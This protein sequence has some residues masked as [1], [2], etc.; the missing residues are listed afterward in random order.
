MRES[1]VRPRVILS[2][3]PHTRRTIR[4]IAGDA[5]RRLAAHRTEFISGLAEKK[6]AAEENDLLAADAMENLDLPRRLVGRGKTTHP[7]MWDSCRTMPLAGGFSRGSSV[8]PALSFRRCFIIISI[9]LIGSQALDVKSCPNLFTTRPVLYW[10]TSARCLVYIAVPD[11]WSVSME[12]PRNEVAGEIGYLGEKP[13][14]QR[15]VKKETYRSM[16]LQLARWRS[17][18]LWSTRIENVLYAFGRS[19]ATPPPPPLPQNMLELRA[20]I[21]TLQGMDYRR[22]PTIRDLYN[23]IPRHL[24]K[25]VGKHDGQASY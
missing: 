14:E 22:A 25:C 19:I 3:T 16:T 20:K 4:A 15:H 8:S 13:V 17:D 11:R 18:E 2:R 21:L 10:R 5:T 23:S 1:G 12:Q 9:T 6:L 7:R 24:A